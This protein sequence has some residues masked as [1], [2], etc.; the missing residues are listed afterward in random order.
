MPMSEV[1]A[2]LAGPGLRLRTGPFLFEIRSTSLLAHRGLTFHYSDHLVEDAGSFADF[3]VSVGPPRSMRRWLAPQ[4]V[5]ALDGRTTFKP[6]PADQAFPMLEW[7]L[8]WCIS[9]YCHQYLI[10]HA[11]V[12]ACGGDAAI[13][14]G[15]PGS[16]KSTIC[17]AMLVRGWRLLSDELTLVQPATGL[18]TPL[19]RPVSL[20]NRS[21]QALQ[22]FATDVALGPVTQG[23]VKGEVSHLKPS[24]ESV[25]RSDEPARPAWIVLP[26]YAEGAAID[27]ER[28]DKAQAF[29][30]L[31]ENAFNYSV[32]GRRGFELLANL[33]DR[34]ECYRLT[35]S[36]LDSATAEL[37]RILRPA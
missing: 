12:I 7:G 29:M 18:V 14:P 6:L 15:A 17:A 33:V 22:A 16:G 9:A 10:V 31:A 37:A 26:R 3:H 34:A 24:Q 8:N 25:Y 35:Y 19:P 32:Y 2:R 28:I 21:I 23:T 30:E 5:F 13:L 36:D 11:A 27:V 4:C 20:K 1:R